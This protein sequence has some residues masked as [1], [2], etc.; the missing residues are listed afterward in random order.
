MHERVPSLG[1]GHLTQP[2]AVPLRSFAETAVAVAQ[3]VGMA[4]QV[5]R[6]SQGARACLLTPGPQ[7]ASKR[8][9]ASW[10]ARQALLSCYS[11][12]S[13]P[14][15]RISRLVLHSGHERNLRPVSSPPLAVPVLG[16]AEQREVECKA[17]GAQPQPRS[18]CR[19]GPSALHPQHRASVHGS[20]HQS[21]CL[22]ARERGHQC[23]LCVQCLQGKR[24]NQHFRPWASGQTPSF[25]SFQ[26]QVGWCTSSAVRQYL[27]CS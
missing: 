14:V 6:S 20:T 13:R 24:A 25:F 22:P 16:W 9:P 21:S 12:K 17:P 19:G 15:G 5:S 26:N 1:K 11:Q 8:K 23:G 18:E 3:R 2:R 10:R 7:G 27:F 4:V